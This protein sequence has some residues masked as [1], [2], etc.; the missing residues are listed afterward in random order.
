MVKKLVVY[1]LEMEFSALEPAI[2][3]GVF[4]KNEDSLGLKVF[5]MAHCLAFMND[6]S[7]ISGNFNYTEIYWK[8]FSLF[9]CKNVYLA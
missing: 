9:G 8:H 1:I 4:S 6:F 7:L 3:Q 5:Y 2:L